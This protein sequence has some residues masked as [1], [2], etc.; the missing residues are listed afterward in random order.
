MIIKLIGGGI[1]NF[2]K[3]Y[4]HNEG[5]FLVGVDAG[6]DIL[7]KNHLKIDLAIGDFDS[8]EIKDIE[9]I[10][11]KTIV[12]K[13]E[14]DKSDLHL[15]LEYIF[16]ND[17]KK[18]YLGNKAIEE[19]IIYNV[20]GNRLDHYQAVINLLVK[21]SHFNM[22]V[23]DLNNLIYIVNYNTKFSKKNY[24][25]ISFF[26]LDEGVIV[27][28]TGFKYDLKKYQ[29]KRFDNLCLSNEIKADEALLETNN[30]KILVIE[31]N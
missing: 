23:I 1:D 26:P 28:L 16:N 17:F 25:Y 19:I 9:K 8:A 22:K 13:P 5:E 31:S 2:S 30:K 6:C 10:S 7:I 11:K 12:Y 18:Q 15:A 3:L 27:S 21:Y 20:T 29:F 4:H 24:K 14:K